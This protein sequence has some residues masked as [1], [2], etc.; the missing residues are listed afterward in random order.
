MADP[1]IN[2]GRLYR[3]DGS[4]EF[5]HPAYMVYPREAD[6]KVMEQALQGLR[7]IAR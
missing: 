3:V 7:E 2:S 1:F 6:S 5:V 4:P